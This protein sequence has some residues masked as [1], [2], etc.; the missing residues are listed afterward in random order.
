MNDKFTINNFGKLKNAEIEINRLTILAG[1]NNTGKSFVSRALYSIIKSVH[2]N[3]FAMVFFPLIDEIREYFEIVNTNKLAELKKVD[4]IVKEINQLILAEN[5]TVV[6]TSQKT[7]SVLSS[8]NKLVSSISKNELNSLENILKALQRK[9]NFGRVVRSANVE[10]DFKSKFSEISKL[11]KLSSNR[12]LHFSISIALKERLVRNFLTQNLLKLSNDQKKPIKFNFNEMLKFEIN[13]K[14]GNY[15]DTKKFSFP[16]SRLFS[17]V[18]YLETRPVWKMKPSNHTVNDWLGR[19]NF[20]PLYVDELLEFKNMESKNTTNP[21]IDLVD[22]VSAAI[23]GKISIDEDGEFFKE[24]N[25]KTIDFNNV[26]SGVIQFGM[27][28]FLIEKNLIDNKSMIF[29]DEPE[30]HLHPRNQII[31]INILIKLVESGVTIVLATHSAEI[32]SYIE[33]YIKKY[34]SF[35][36]NLAL[37]LFSESGVNI[38]DCNNNEERIDNIQLELTEPFYKL[39][40]EDLYYE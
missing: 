30:T 19:Y 27:L 1:V 14:N 35:N 3:P 5:K 40:N 32:L 37:N 12:F 34:H 31:F 4:K 33:T 22:K 24:R 6:L 38:S 28:G 13:N 18:F 36:D 8:I 20:N 16:I 23:N 7:K 21:Y 15:V 25:G 29:I 2:E 11:S 39:F 17:S 26:S 10:F 9:Q